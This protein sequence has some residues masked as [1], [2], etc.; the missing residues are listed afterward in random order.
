[1]SNF[2]IAT[3][4]LS[5]CFS[6]HWDIKKG[7]DVKSSEKM[8]EVFAEII[9][10]INTH[11]ID[12][13]CFQEFPVEIVGD[14]ALINAILSNTRLQHYYAAATCPSFLFQGGKIGIAIFSKEEILY[15]NLSYFANPNL[16]KI[17]A[18][19][20]VYQTFDKG[21]ITAAC[22]H[23]NKTFHVI[24]GHAIGF[25]PFGVAAESY[26]ESYV[27][28]LDKVKELHNQ[29]S[30]MIVIGDFNTEYLLELLPELKK[31]VSDVD[32]GKTTP[33]GMM[34][35]YYYPDGRKLDYFLTTPHFSVHR[36]DKIHNFSDHYLCIFHCT[37]I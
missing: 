36:I 12:I 29:N 37:I 5:E 16:T 27:P 35:G 20:E 6:T 1:M 11:D 3:W 30:Q 31:Y 34:E 17:S 14:Q 26:P 9:E 13:I 10:Q 4:N 23:H 19:G 8:H 33:A 2:I 28:L 25:S 22:K 24:T 7:I 15:T 21:I 32:T 18:T